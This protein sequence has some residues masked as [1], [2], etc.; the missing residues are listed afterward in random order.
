[1]AADGNQ[2]LECWGRLAVC[3]RTSATKGWGNPGTETFNPI[4]D[5]KGTPQQKT[6]IDEN[7]DPI[8]HQGASTPAQALKNGFTDYSP[9]HKPI[10]PISGEVGCAKAGEM[11]TFGELVAAHG[12]TEAHFYVDVD[13]GT[14]TAFGALAEIKAL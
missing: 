1:M 2:G 12:L 11:T 14:L 9:K 5:N 8:T 6:C 10:V 13:D 3:C 7:A 4:A